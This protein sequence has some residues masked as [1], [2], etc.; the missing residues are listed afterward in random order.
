MG[1]NSRAAFS[2]PAYD[3][4][5]V[6]RL[7]EHHAPAAPSEVREYVTTEPTGLLNEHGRP[8][9]RVRRIKTGVDHA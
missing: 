6:R 8:I 3:P 7:L 2:W 4:D 1:S 5:T 9:Y